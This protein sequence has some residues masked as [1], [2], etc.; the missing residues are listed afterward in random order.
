MRDILEQIIQVR[1]VLHTAGT[2]SAPALRAT[3]AHAAERTILHSAE[4]G[5]GATTLLL[6]QLSQ[7]H[8]VFA[9]DVGESVSSVRN[10]PLLR[11]GVVKFVDGPSQRTL[12]QF[13]F[14]AKLQLALIDGPHAY[15]FP[16]LEYYYL[17][18]HLDAGA[19]LVLDDIHIRSIHN[20]FEFLRRD[21]MFRLEAVVRNTALFTRTD[22]PT[23]D[24]CGD[25]WEQQSYNHDTLWRY[26]WR[27]RL[28]KVLPRALREAAQ[29]SVD[30]RKLINI[31]A[32]E[33]GARV[34]ASG[35]VTGTAEVPNDAHLWVLV[36]RKDVAGWWPQGGGP[37]PVSNGAWH[38]EVKYGDPS[39]AGHV[40]EIAA[41]AVPI[42]VH[43]RW[44]QWVHSV[45]ET[46][47][48]PPLQ[49]PSGTALIATAYRTVKRR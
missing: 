7:S 47:M 43:E 45:N 35:E 20:L 8:T 23:F 1:T 26:D 6:S 41:A 24:P 28:G 22:A 31:I 18:P 21:T 44:L 16:D 38:V 42:A 14:D 27:S 5:C 13:R 4:T 12:P 49:L 36:H 19:L 17:Y 37:V 39:D 10:S 11:S 9:L 30:R 40:F 46:G 2:V 34:A 32:P 15:P 29:R 3:A 48:Y 25:G 33:A